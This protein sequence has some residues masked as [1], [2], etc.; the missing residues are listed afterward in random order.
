MSKIIRNLGEI[1]RLQAQI[2]SFK[3]RKASHVGREGGKG[4]AAVL[5]GVADVGRYPGPAAMLGGADVGRYPGP[6]ALLSIFRYPA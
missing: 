5:R 2:F 4:C 3:M 6:V 1:F